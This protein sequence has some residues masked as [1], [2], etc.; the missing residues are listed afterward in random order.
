[1]QGTNAGCEIWG[2]RGAAEAGEQERTGE[3]REVGRAVQRS[4]GTGV[5]PGE[6]GQQRT[7][8]AGGRA[9][10]DTTREP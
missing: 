4:V 3:D 6:P 9:G 10:R 5:K 1:M 7:A 2:Q 8:K